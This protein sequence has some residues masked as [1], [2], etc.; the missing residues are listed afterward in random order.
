MEEPRY[1]VLSAC[2][3]VEGSVGRR[4]QNSM[5]WQKQRVV[6]QRTVAAP[7]LAA[8]LGALLAAVACRPPRAA[9]RRQSD[10]PAGASSVSGTERSSAAEREGRDEPADG[11]PADLGYYVGYRICEAYFA[12]AQD[13]TRALRDMFTIQDF[14]AFLHASGYAETFSTR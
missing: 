11:R 4:D 9:P 2:K 10:E 6:W 13:P 7:L 1:P 14:H 3:Y 8:C 12:R 5:F